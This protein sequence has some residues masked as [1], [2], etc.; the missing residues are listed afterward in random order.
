[1]RY[2]LSLYLVSLIVLLGSEEELLEA[3]VI[4]VLVNRI[5]EVHLDGIYIV[6]L[7]LVFAGSIVTHHHSLGSLQLLLVFLV[8]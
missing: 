1:M 6:L 7:E 5:G 4:E 2:L 8:L 3:L